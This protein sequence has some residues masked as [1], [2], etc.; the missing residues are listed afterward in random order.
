[1]TGFYNCDL[2]I[3]INPFISCSSYPVVS[4]GFSTYL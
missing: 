1:M 3:F 2:A 4:L